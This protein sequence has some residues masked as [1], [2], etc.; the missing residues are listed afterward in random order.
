MNAETLAKRTNT[1]VALLER[2]LRGL[3]AMYAVEEIGVSGYGPTNISRA[4]ATAKGVSM[5][6]VLYETFVFLRAGL[7]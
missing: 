1:D 2:V 3:A 6:R 5:A 7:L 4:F